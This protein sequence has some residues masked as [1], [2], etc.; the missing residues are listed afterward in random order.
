LEAELAMVVRH[1]N[2]RGVADGGHAR[3]EGAG[4][5]VENGLEKPVS[6]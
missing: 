4:G 6:R 5:N 3:M 2:A 1:A